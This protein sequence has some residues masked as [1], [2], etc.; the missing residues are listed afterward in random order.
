MTQYTDAQE[1][2]VVIAS[3]FRL[4]GGT[5]SSIAEEVRAQSAAGMTTGLLHITGSVTNYAIGWSKHVQEV[6]DLPGVELLTP[7]SSVRTKLMI[8]RHP[9]VAL[10][11]RNIFKKYKPQN[12][13]IVANHAAI[14][15]AGKEHYN[16]EETH[17]KIHDIFGFSPA[18]A[19]IGPVVRQT[20]LQQTTEVPLR[21]R[22]WSNIF[23][24]SEA[25]EVSARTSFVSD[26][27]VIGRHSRPQPGKWP[28]S[29][30]D[31]VSAYPE[32]G[33]YR[34]RILG[35]AA[36]AKRHLG[37][38]PESWDV[39][40]FGGMD[41]STFLRE[42][43]FWVYMHHP[44]LR[45]AFGRAAM[46]ALAAGCVAIMPPY[47]KELFGDAALYAEPS[48]VLALVDS[49][50]AE[51]AK[52]F[53]QSRRAQEFAQSFSREMHIDRLAEFGVAARDVQATTMV[54]PPPATLG[55]ALTA[56]DP[57]GGALAFIHGTGSFAP[58]GDVREE[59]LPA[60]WRE[61]ALRIDI[62][63]HAPRS[64]STHGVV[65]ISTAERM[66]MAPEKWQEYLTWR[67]DSVMSSLPFSVIVFSGAVP[68][69]AVIRVLAK[70]VAHKIWLRSQLQEGDVVERR[71][72]LEARVAAE[73]RFHMV[74]DD[75]SGVSA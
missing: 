40:P 44:D 21:A 43:D 31:I 64:L 57:E 62:A 8:L 25:N 17:K 32:T 65:E 70:S 9:T 7:F 46:E 28:A 36:V 10:S 24:L 20:M 2:D 4:P 54:A 67:L 60:K 27:P 72:I 30:V 6:I 73:G 19:P 16:I 5:T 63:P 56:F 18:W 41:P 71:R 42:I 59:N 39:I 52:F 49:F 33:P 55:E 35:G 68:S 53:S 23:A 66:N 29:A 38:V 47:M 48:D 37:Y 12:V 22:D 34:V 14:D 11:N 3:D 45:E 26:R 58:S 75:P 51:P 50:F 1:L 69:N 61:K 13:L 74:I 15:G